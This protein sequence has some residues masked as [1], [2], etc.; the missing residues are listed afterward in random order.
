M[1]KYTI[2]DFDQLERL[3]HW[4]GDQVI[5]TPHVLS[6]VSDLTG[7]LYGKELDAVRQNF[8]SAVEQI[9][10][11]YDLAKA[12]VAHPMFSRFGLTDV[13]I[14]TVC[15]RGILVLTDDLQLQLALQRRGV[16]AL[17]FNHIRPLALEV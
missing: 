8:R 16:D 7:S 4:F 17:N 2:E 6:Q 9:E 3:I 12:L 1:Q 15:S 11:S 13:A 14:A 10:E 5:T